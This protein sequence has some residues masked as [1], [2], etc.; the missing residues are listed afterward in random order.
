MSEVSSFRM[1]W[2]IWI[3]AL[4]AT[5]LRQIPVLFNL[6]AHASSGDRMWLPLGYIPKDW[7]AYTALIHQ[8]AWT[9]R[10]FALFNPFTSEPQTG[11]FIFLFH[12]SLATIH[13]ATGVDAF[14]LLEIS[15]CVLIPL[16]ILVLWWFL[17][18]LLPEMRHRSW[19]CWLAALGGGLEFAIRP[20]ISS[21]PASIVQSSREQLW[22]LNGWSLFTAMYNPLWLVA[23]ILLLLALRLSLKP[24]GP[25]TW[26]ERLY[27]AGL[28]TL[29]WF[30]HP[31]TG[32][33]LLAILA[34]RFMTGWCLGEHRPWRSL[35]KVAMP[36]ALG[37]AIIGAVTSWQ[38]QDSVYRLSTGQ[39]LGSQNASLFWCPVT[40]FLVGFF[41]MRGV[42]RLFANSHPWRFAIMGWILAALFLLSSP[43]T[44]GYK[45]IMYLYL[46]VC[47]AAAPAIDDFVVQGTDRIL[48]RLCRLLVVVGLFAA[49]MGNTITAWGDIRSTSVPPREW[50]DIV[51]RLRCTPPGNV[52]APPWLGNIIPSVTHHRVSVG[53]WFMTPDWDTKAKFYQRVVGD[54][55]SHPETLRR[56]LKTQSIRYV[57]VPRSSV[58][59]FRI[60]IGSA[61]TE[62]AE[63]D[64][65]ALLQLS[66]QSGLD[67][68]D[69]SLGVNGHL[70]TSE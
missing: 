59:K 66:E 12:Q 5:A 36:V 44:N 64:T 3:A 14:W 25:S 19:A 27:L 68:S 39:F 17:G 33:A 41:A 45:F 58:P 6:T 38:M 21:L 15:R 55:T 20:L 51:E 32:I 22:H 29:V 9:G 13:A 50:E 26:R 47:I 31:Y 28:L 49:S 52:F 54:P 63:F 70:R 65:L 56:F 23:F 35:P 61:I 34:S 1:P 11:R 48:S 40:L 30:T 37:L 69:D 24:E 60:C 53:H 42:V 7:L 46:P 16:L 10:W 2:H 4:V 67:Y 62:C 57:I 8:P 18:P 43:L